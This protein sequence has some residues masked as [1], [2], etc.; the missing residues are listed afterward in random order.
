[1]NIDGL[2]IADVKRILDVFGG[3]VSAVLEDSG[4]LGEQ[5][6]GQYVL[7][8]SVNEGLNAGILRHAHRDGCVLE[9]ARRLWYHKPKDS[10][11]SWYEGVAISGLSD[12]SKVSPKAPIKVIVEDYSI[13]P[14]TTE[15]R[16]SIESAPSQKS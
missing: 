11:L 14:C 9:D 2:T 16:A 13:T 5:Y 15:A 1:M 7:I 6:V 8:R 3:R 10:S 4:R 12:D